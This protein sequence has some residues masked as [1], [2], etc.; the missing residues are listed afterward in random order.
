MNTLEVE[1]LADH[2]EALPCLREW[3][4]REWA[5]YYGPDGPGDATTDLRESCNR[6]ELPI[7]V[8]AILG[9]EI[10]GTAALKA[11]SVSTH[12]HLTPWLAALLVRPEFRRRGIAE[13]LIAEIEKKAQELG[14]HSIYVGTGEGSGTPESP[15]RKRGWEFVEKGP[16]FVSEVSIFKKAL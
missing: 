4:E 11:E 12:K 9:G 5:P 8:V 3:F 14:F 15:L 2:Q 16:Y 10:V 7:A 1:L 6:E 13:R